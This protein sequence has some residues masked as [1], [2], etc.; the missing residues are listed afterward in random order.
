[1]RDDLDRRKVL[2]ALATAAASTSAALGGPGA[3]A[4]D[5]A[6]APDQDDRVE[7]E[8][9]CGDPDATPESLIY[10][11]VKVQNAILGQKKAS[12]EPRVQDIGPS[13]IAQ[14]AREIGV[15]RQG[16]QSQVTQYLNLFDLPFAAGG[17]PLAFCAAGLSYA[18]VKLYAVRKG[19][20]D[21]SMSALRNYLGDIDHYHFYPSPSVQEMQWVALGKRRWL[22]RGQAT[23]A[24]APRPGWLVV[25]DWHGK[26]VDH[27]G[28]VSG[29]SGGRLQTIEF[30]TTTTAGGNVVNGG[31]VARKQRQLNATVAGFIRPELERAA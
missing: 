10:N 27:V 20:G 15:S 3:R 23:G 5:A 4:Q 16:N 26:G 17:K 24:L 14:A 22:P 28:L 9:Q 7:T 8:E 19:N 12:F 21:V 11:P 29:F 31:V 25:Y 6:D 2:L 18:A 30:N 13:L 1:M